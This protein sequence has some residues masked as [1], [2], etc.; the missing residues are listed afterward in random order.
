M[1]DSDRRASERF[2]VTSDTACT[3]VSPVLEDFGAVR[4]KNVSNE[5]VGLVVNQAVET[6]LLLVVTLVNKPKSFK[7]NVMARVVHVTPQAGGAYLLGCALT[8]P[9]TYDELCAMVM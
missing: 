7:K 3:F 9:L 6:G 8:E 1:P 4:I 5:G 2:P